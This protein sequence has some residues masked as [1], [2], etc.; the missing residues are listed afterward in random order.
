MGDTPSPPR[1]PESET[2]PPSYTPYIDPELT[3][4]SGDVN[5]MR[6]FACSG[7]TELIIDTSGGP[8]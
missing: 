7:M 8:N 2:S 1:D 6:P 3:E 5:C 4:D